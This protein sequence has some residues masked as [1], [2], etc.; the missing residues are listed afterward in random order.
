VG[1]AHAL[2]HP[3]SLVRRE[4][5]LEER[6]CT[7]VIAGVEGDHPEV[8]L[9]HDGLDPERLGQLDAALQMSRGGCVLTALV[10]DDAQD[11]VRL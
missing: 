2:H 6:Q 10:R 1:E 4:D 5:L 11:D 9:F 7:D 8:Q 3:V